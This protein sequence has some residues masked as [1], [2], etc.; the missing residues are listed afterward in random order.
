MIEVGEEVPS[1]TLPPQTGL[2]V[3]NNMVR[4]PYERTINNLKKVQDASEK[5]DIS[6][7]SIQPMTSATI[8]TTQDALKSENQG[9]NIVSG[10]I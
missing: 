10:D 8:D 3:A 9:T 6:E 5:P 2:P 4:P 1:D 7:S